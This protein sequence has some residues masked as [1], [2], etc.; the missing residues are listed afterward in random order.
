MVS[1][2]LPPVHEFFFLPFQN[3]VSGRERK[4]REERDE[5]MEGTGDSRQTLS[6]EKRGKKRWAL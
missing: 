6:G 2:S 3:C 1:R 5:E 4:G